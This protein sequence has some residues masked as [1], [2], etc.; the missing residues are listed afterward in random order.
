VSGGPRPNA[1]RPRDRIYHINGKQYKTMR[2]A[3]VGEN[4]SYETIRNWCKSDKYPE[5]YAEML[6]NNS[7]PLP[8]PKV[9]K[10][11]KSPN[12]T[13]ELPNDILDAAKCADM[14]PLDYMLA[15]MRDPKVNKERRDRMA[16]WAAPYCHAR[17]NKVRGKKEERADKAKSAG[18]G[19]FAP[20]EPPKLKAVK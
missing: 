18:K 12:D 17:S 7:K 10:Q 15:V 5:C 13:E 19:R 11:L 16:N 14:D 1:G 8:K 3:A 20:A 2:A 6:S 4:V 9:P